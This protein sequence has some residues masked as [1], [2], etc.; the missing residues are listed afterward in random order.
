MIP[1]THRGKNM[2]K[3]KTRSQLGRLSKEKCKRTEREVVALLQ[4]Q[5]FADAL[6]TQ[7]YSGKGGGPSD[8]IC[9][10]S[11]PRVHIEVKA[12]QKIKLGNQALRDA[13]LQ[14]MRDAEG[15]RWW[16][17]FWR[18]DRSR[19]TWRLTFPSPFG[20]CA[21]TVTHPAEMARVLRELNKKEIA[22]EPVPDGRE[23]PHYT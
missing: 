6:R 4:E 5:G 19:V 3:K 14:A 15:D 8:V 13:M 9:P 20:L 2:A 21:P 7:Q 23:S 17:V 12:D 18:R 16:V 10:K 22:N 1:A 11:L